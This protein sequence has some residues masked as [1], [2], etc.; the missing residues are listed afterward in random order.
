MFLKKK[1]LLYLNH[2]Y[3]STEL[4]K[5]THKK[6]HQNPSLLTDCICTCGSKLEQTQ[7]QYRG[8]YHQDLGSTL[9]S[10][11]NTQVLSDSAV[12]A[13]I[14]TRRPAGAG[15]EGAVRALQGNWRV[16]GMSVTPSQ[17]PTNLILYLIQRRNSET[18]WEQKIQY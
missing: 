11:A 16:K 12:P 3:I 6:A 1:I 17:N 4:C 2:V 15:R 13:A 18:I 8:V 14:L 7:Y 10:G 5:I 9:C